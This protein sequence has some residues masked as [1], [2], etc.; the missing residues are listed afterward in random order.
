MRR[1]EG[2]SL[3]VRA[4]SITLGPGRDV[5]CVRACA[6]IIG[7]GGG[8]RR[9]GKSGARIAEVD[10]ECVA[11]VTAA[12]WVIGQGRRNSEGLGSVDQASIGAVNGDSARAQRS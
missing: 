2:Q 5:E 6:N 9:R 1:G 4:S 7:S 10:L 3:R 11:I 12:E 8:A